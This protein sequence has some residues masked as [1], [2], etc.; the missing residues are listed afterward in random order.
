MWFVYIVRC[1]DDTLYTGIAK[2]VARRV[3]EHNSNNLLA[4]NYT[5]ARRPVAMVYEEA[6][7]T[8]SAAARREYEI[9]QMTRQRK[10]ELLKT[11]LRLKRRVNARA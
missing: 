9:K 10:E 3:E 6:V 5:R 1:A 11:R 4:A 2:D 7:E 8:R